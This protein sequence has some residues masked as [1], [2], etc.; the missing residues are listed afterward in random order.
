[1]PPIRSLVFKRLAYCFKLVAVILSLG[2][3]MPT[4]SCY[5]EKGLVY[6]TI[7]ALLGR[8]PSSYTKYTKLNM[9]LSCN[10]RLVFIVKYIFLIRSYIL[11]SL[12]LPY[13]I[14]LRVSCNG[15]CK[16]A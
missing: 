6:I 3:I 4:Y 13:L 8:Q 14:C 5:A 12:R 9:R 16:E 7:M 15:Y 10:I 11:R 1:M 2:K